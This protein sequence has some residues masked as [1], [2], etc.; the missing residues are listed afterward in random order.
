M[1]Q[2]IAASLGSLGFGILFGLRG[3]YLA[4]V[5]CGSFATWGIW[6]LMNALIGESFIDCLL[7]S[8]FAAFSAQLLARSFH[9]PATLFFI[10]FVLPLVPGGSLYYTL[11]Y[12]VQGDAL[13]ARASAH[14]TLIAALAIASGIS[15]V[16]AIRE[17]RTAAS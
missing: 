16:T 5:A 8:A 9:A 1:I 3:K 6:L 10:P 2:L 15:F 13:L 12:A 7:A 14:D 11:A 4:A 17:L